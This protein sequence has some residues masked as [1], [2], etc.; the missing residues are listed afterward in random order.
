M[1]KYCNVKP[2][3]GLACEEEL[4]FFSFV[5]GNVPILV[6]NWPLVYCV[7]VAGRVLEQ[8]CY[9]TPPSRQVNKVSRSDFESGAWKEL[10]GTGA[11]EHVD[12]ALENK[13][14]FLKY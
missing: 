10:L 5:T 4:Q 8:I 13:R 11:P 7:A 14:V 6:L 1:N 2:E 9:K 12:L 3:M